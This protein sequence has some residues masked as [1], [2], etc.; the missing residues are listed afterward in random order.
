M[1]GHGVSSPA[2]PIHHE[3]TAKKHMHLT[4]LAALLLGVAGT[5]S[6]RDVGDRVDHRLDQRGDRVE[7]RLDQKGDR[8]EARYDRR[9]DWADN[10]DRPGL[11]NRLEARGNRIDGRLD[12]KGERADNRLDRRGDRF[13]RRWDRRH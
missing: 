5:A 6:A 4:A 12:R 1:P 2:T 11:S 7:Q 10:H 8:I 9:A 3:E 13:D